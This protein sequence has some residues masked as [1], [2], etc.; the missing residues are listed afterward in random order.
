MPSTLHALFHLILNKTPEREVDTIL[1]RWRNFSLGSLQSFCQDPI[2][3]K[4]QMCSLSF[5]SNL[6]HVF[7]LY[8]YVP[9]SLHHEL[10]SNLCGFLSSSS[11]AT[12]RTLSA[13]TLKQSSVHWNKG[14]LQIFPSVFYFYTFMLTF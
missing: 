6:T 8:C 13:R 12:T 5:G 4:E 2:T 10:I 9:F 3:S 7:S 14:D 11:M 1:C